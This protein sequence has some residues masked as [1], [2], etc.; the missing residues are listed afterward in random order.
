MRQDTLSVIHKS[1]RNLSTVNANSVNSFVQ[2]QQDHTLQVNQQQQ[3]LL[4]SAPLHQS[5]NSL[6]G[7]ST[8][9][10]PSIIQI[11]EPWRHTIKTCA[12]IHTF[13]FFTLGPLR[14][15]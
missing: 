12:S 13:G 7:H 14:H 3:Q 1:T 9:F 15:A 6:C 2:N 10:F 5:F 11:S 8:V 4:I